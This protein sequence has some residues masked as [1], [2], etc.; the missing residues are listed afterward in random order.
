MI[1]KKAAL[2]TVVLGFRDLRPMEPDQ[3]Y[4]NMPDLSS[5]N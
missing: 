1:K 2:R 3:V 5:A 4:H